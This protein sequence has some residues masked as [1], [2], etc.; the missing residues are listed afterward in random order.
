MD[1]SWIEIVSSNASKPWIRPRKRAA[2]QLPCKCLNAVS[3]PRWGDWYPSHFKE[4]ASQRW[5]WWSFIAGFRDVDYCRCKQIQSLKTRR[6]P[7]RSG[8]HKETLKSG[9]QMDPFSRPIS[10]WDVWLPLWLWYAITKNI[11]FRVSRKYRWQTHSSGIWFAN[12]LG[13]LI[14]YNPQVLPEI[15]RK[16]S[17]IPSHLLNHGNG[18]CAGNVPFFV[19]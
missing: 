4:D 7:T 1:R 15:C 19:S 17:D 3:W 12:T 10:W 14:I 9:C 8:E 6:A 2:K 16:I 5:G 13:Q 11:A 18:K